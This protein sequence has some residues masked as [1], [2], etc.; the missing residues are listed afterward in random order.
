MMRRSI[1]YRTGVEPLVICGLLALWPGLSMVADADADESVTAGETS[2][3]NEAG[4]LDDVEAEARPAMSDDA[5][6]AEDAADEAEAAAEAEPAEAPRRLTEEERLIEEVHALLGELRRLRTELAEAQLAKSQMQR[7]LKELR[8]FIDD[9]HEY[10]SDFEEYQRIREIKQREQRR[11]E[12]R[13]ARERYLRE[14]EERMRQ[15][16]IARQ[17]RAEQRAAERQERQFRERGFE[18]LGMNTFLGRMAY[19]YR[20][21]D[22]LRTRITYDPF[23]GFFTQRDFRDRIDYSEMNISGAVINAS[24]EVRNIGVAITFFD[25]FGNQVG[26]EIIEVNN[27]RPNVPYPFTSTVDMA[28]DRPFTTSSSY[29]L[30]ADRAML[31]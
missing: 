19:Q 8:A 17:Q 11:R 30:Y 2:V 1:R 16:K 12:Q 22:T 4:G 6:E 15:Q 26:H 18:S 27:A 9:H 25:D 3:T 28:L 10:G 13:D 14:R 23:F 29:V 21:R 5:G 7:E 20:V 24:D 31:E